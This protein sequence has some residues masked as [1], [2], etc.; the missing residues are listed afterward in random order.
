MRRQSYGGSKP[1]AAKMFDQNY[2]KKTQYATSENLEARIAIHRRFGTNPY[3]WFQWV[4]DHLGLQ[5]GMQ[6]VEVGCGPGSLWQANIMRLPEKVNVKLGDL[7]SGMVRQARDGLQGRPAFQFF[8]VD[9]QALP[10]RAAHFDLVI[11]NH[12]LYHVPDMQQGLAEARRVLKPG[13]RLV[14]ATNGNAHM[15]ELYT[16]V[17]AHIPI[18]QQTLWSPRRFSLENGQD[19]LAPYFRRIEVIPFLD[20]LIVTEAEPLLAYIRSMWSIGLEQASARSS[21]ALENEVHALTAAPG[22]FTIHKS[23]GLIIGS[24]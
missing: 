24:D 22:G 4:G 13:G 6:I 12:M 19:L 23:Q 18:S 16:L 17:Q 9:L 5:E 2:L 20:D 14:A 15:G 11:A 21:A 8:T 1:K 7:S 10:F 3:S